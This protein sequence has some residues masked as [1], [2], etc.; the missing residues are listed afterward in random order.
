MTLDDRPA[1]PSALFAP[2]SVRLRRE[3]NGELFLESGIPLPE[4]DR[5]VG[6]WLLRWAAEAPDR[7]LFAE[8]AGEG[9]RRLSYAEAL[10]A[11]VATAGWLLST[12]ASA[13]RP[14]M[15]LSENAIDLAVLSLAAMHVGVPICVVS[16]A[17]SLM[18]KDHARLK[19]MTALLTPAVVFASDSGPYGPALD[20]IRDLHGG[21][22]LL[23]RDPA[24][25]G[26]QIFAEAR[27]PSAAGVVEDAFAR[28]GPGTTAKL[29]FTSGSTGAPK[30]VINTHR[31]LTTNQEANREIWTVLKTKPPVIVDWLPWSHTFGGNFCTHMVLRNGGTMHIDDGRP[32]PPLIGRTV[33]NC[34]LARP[35]LALNVPRGFAM[36]ADALEEDAAFRE[37]FFGIDFAMNA[38]AGLPPGLRA[39]FARLSRESLGRELPFVGAWGSTETSPLATHCQFATED[40]ANVG[41]PVPGV[42]LKLVPNG[43][44][45]EARVKGPNVMPGYFRDPARTAEAMDADGFYRIG[46]A[47]RLVDEADPARGLS[48]DGRVSEDFK[49]ASGT[50]VSVGALRLAGIDALAPLAQDIVVAGHDRDAVGFLLVPNEA[51]CRALAGLPAEAPLADVLASLAVRAAV[52][53]GLARLRREGGG[54]SRWAA[55]ARFLT[56]PPSPDA[57]E[58]TDK[59]YLNQRRLLANRPEEVEALFGDDP[60]R[61]VAPDRPG[62]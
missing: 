45:L 49:L 37:A 14:V 47:L 23:S 8:R 20:A 40:P 36:L 9:W 33:E 2:P 27:A 44:K 15:A 25:R 38:A 6:D 32:A 50:W 46:D 3:P 42:T 22:E 10:E 11:A 48:F 29:L 60:D 26:A 34:K 31:M 41:L 18:S 55:R 52:A 39:R 30:A 35:T 5:R 59:A 24:G 1:A 43:G 13:E 4:G 56:A 58:V 17:Y 28:V 51:A 57:G 61:Y 54:T 19:A 21:V 12:E 62:P 16:S 7:T 53:E